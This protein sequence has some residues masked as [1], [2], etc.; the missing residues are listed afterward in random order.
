MS[1]T[2]EMK[3]KHLIFMGV[4][5]VVLA[6]IVCFPYQSTID[7]TKK[8][9]RIPAPVEPPDKSSSEEINSVS[10]NLIKKSTYGLNDTQDMN[11]S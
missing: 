8:V 5:L 3:K 2:Y 4:A 6:I 11:P 9:E 7:Y 1:V 10:Q